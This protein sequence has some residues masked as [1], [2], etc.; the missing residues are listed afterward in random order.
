MIFHYSII[1]KASDPCSCKHQLKWL[2]DSR[3]HERRMKRINVER[4]EHEHM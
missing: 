1:L 3:S 4:T 2:L